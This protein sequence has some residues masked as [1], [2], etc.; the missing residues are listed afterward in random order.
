MRAIR[1][2]SPAPLLAANW[3]PCAAGGG[4]EPCHADRGDC[5]RP[6]RHRVEV[7]APDQAALDA[8]E[9][10]RARLVLDVD[11]RE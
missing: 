8:K 9:D 11:R 5:L 10:Q 3:L 7:A 4:M 6:G 1:S 2:R